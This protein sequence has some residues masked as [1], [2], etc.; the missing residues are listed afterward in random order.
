MSDSGKSAQAYQGAETAS[1]GISDYHQMSFLAEQTVKRI[2]TAVLVKIVKVT[3]TPG[4]KGPIGTV[5]VIP[6][7]NQVDG[8]G[9]ATK[10]QVVHK[11]S[12][13]RYQGGKMAV[14]ID[15]QVGD[16]GMMMVADKDTS[17]VRANQDQANPGSARRFDLADG[18]YVGMCLSKGEPEQYIRLFEEDNKQ[19]MQLHDKNGNDVLMNDEGTTIT[20]KSGNKIVMS[21]TGINLNP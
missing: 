12:Y 7:V 1:S 21:S 20:D 4:K 17:S 9:N 15:P 3:N 6:L 16:I 14:I 10:H 8:Y 13:F 11:L 5:D 19:G 2:S 18:L